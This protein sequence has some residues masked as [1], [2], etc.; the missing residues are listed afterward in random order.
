MKNNIVVVTYLLFALIGCQS[1]P[2]RLS[3]ESYKEFFSKDGIGKTDLNSNRMTLARYGFLS[4]DKKEFV[5]AIPYTPSHLHAVIEAAPEKLN[6]EKRKSVL[7]TQLETQTCFEI[8][9]EGYS[10]EQVD[11]EKW[12]VELIQ[13]KKSVSLSTKIYQA[14]HKSFGF[15]EM[16]VRP[17]KTRGLA[18]GKPP[19]DFTK[20]FNLKVTSNTEKSRSVEFSWIQRWN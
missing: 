13:D 16:K 14:N 3:G 4:G 19:I 10:P 18:C 5:A 17:I 11:I 1:T 7:K 2:T 8:E 9:A 20:P 12:Q 6:D 15:F